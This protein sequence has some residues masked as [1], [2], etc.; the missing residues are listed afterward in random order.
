MNNIRQGEHLD[1]RPFGVFP[2]DDRVTRVTIVGKSRVT[3]YS[4]R[5]KRIDQWGNVRVYRLKVK[6]DMPFP[7]DRDGRNYVKMSETFIFDHIGGYK[8][9]PGISS[10]CFLSARNDS[11]P[12]LN[13]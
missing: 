3:V 4:A 2:V 10:Y 13:W 5:S 6:T 8:R 7:L 1:S 9:P 12:F 11:F